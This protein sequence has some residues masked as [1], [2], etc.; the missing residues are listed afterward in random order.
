MPHVVGIANKL[1]NIEVV[2][3]QFTPEG[4]SEP[5][6]YDSLHLTG[7]INGDV[8]QLRVKLSRTQALVLKAMKT[9]NGSLLDDEK[10]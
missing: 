10:E 6:D 8:E 7:E 2:H 4:A 1:L 3:D 5:I 9:Q